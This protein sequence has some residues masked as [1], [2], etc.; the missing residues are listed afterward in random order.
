MSG[1]GTERLTMK[2]ACEQ[3]YLQG[4]ASKAAVLVLAVCFIALTFAGCNDQQVNGSAISAPLDMEYT[5]VNPLVCEEI[6]EISDDKFDCEYIKVSGLKDE[7]VERAINDRIKAVYDELRV[8]DIPPYRGIKARI[9]EDSVL[10]NQ[11]IYVNIAG[12]FNNILS[13]VFSKNVS[14]QDPDSAEEEKDPAYYDGSRYFTEAETLNFDLNTGEEITLKDLFCDNVDYMELVNESMGKFLTENHAEDE[15][16]YLGSYG[17]LKLVESFKGLS[18][19]QKFAVYPYGIAFFFDYRTPQF[20][21]GGLAVCPTINY[22]E[23]GDNIAVTERFFDEGVNLYTSEAPLVKAFMMKEEANDIAGND[24]FQSGYVNIYQS[25]GYSSGL[26]KEIR[27][28]LEKMKEPDQAKL[29]EI[30]QYFS[31]MTESEIY[32][33]GPGSYE[34]MVYGSR[35]GGCI[36]V[37]GHSNIYLPDQFEQIM[38]FHCFDEETLKEL[39]LGDIFR[40]GYDYKPAV[41]EAIR[42]TVNSYDGTYEK[43]SEG[44][45]SDVQLE[46]VYD[47]IG[48]FNLTADAVVIPI[49]HPEKKNQ[50]YGLSVYLTYEEL[51]CDNLNIFE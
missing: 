40:T 45:Y 22:S 6:K 7:Q 8:Q 28:R 24:N 4:R 20:D 43:G 10:R 44:K 23:F 33:R 50:T 46:E 25:W 39:S 47:Q 36:N 51:G 3:N 48:G 35:T 42:N 26:P 17:E 1:L 21:T 38:D 32:E 31:G 16:Y 11:M 41:I 13:V 15:G 12:N 49:I 9:P 5:V 2:R 19:D 14:Y 18:E 34:I 30:K 37:S 27:N 29:N